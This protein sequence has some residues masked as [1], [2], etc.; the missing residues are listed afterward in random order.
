M[1]SHFR[2]DVK[3]DA[4]KHCL[5]LYGLPL[6]EKLP[7]GAPPDPNVAELATSLLDPDEENPFLLGYIE[8]GDVSNRSQLLHILTSLYVSGS[9][10][11]L[12]SPGHEAINH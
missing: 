2:S 11:E 10:I 3:R 4:R 7:K 5:A 8:E 12:R 6:Q 1:T 9:L